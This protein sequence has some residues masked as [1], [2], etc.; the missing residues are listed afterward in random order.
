MLNLCLRISLCIC[1][2][3]GGMSAQLRAGHN[4]GL[5]IAYECLG[6]NSY[7]ITVNL[8]RDCGDPEPPASSIS[9]YIYSSCTNLGFETFDL[10]FTEEV[11]QLCPASLPN[12]TC[13]G[14]LEPGVE[15]NIYKKTV[16]L[17][18]CADWRMVVAEQNRS[19]VVNLVS[20][21]TSRIHVEAF[22]NNV[23][24]VCNSSPELGV[25]NL[26]YICVS[27]PL[28]YNLGFSEPDG[29]SLVYAFVPAL[30]SL[31]A[32]APEEMEYVGVYSGEEPI[33]GASINSGNGQI[34]VTPNLTG[35]FNAAVK[36]SE[37][38]D[39]VLIGEV[40]QDFLFLINPCPVPTPAP[41][42]GS[43]SHVS[44]GGY[45]LDNATIGI[46]EEDD[47][48][49]EIAFT[50]NDSSYDISI[51][52]TIETII[53][54]ATLTTTGSNPATAQFCGSMP[55][56]LSAG[57]FLII[58]TDD[59]CPV[60]GQTFY[61][62]DFVPRSPVAAGPDTLLCAGQP[63][64]LFAQNGGEHTWTYLNGM[65][66]PPGAAF[67][68][69]P[70]DNPQVVTDTTTTLLV[71]GAF[72]N[73][74]CANTA[75]VT[76]TVPLTWELDA[77][78]ES[79]LG[80]D[81]GIDIIISDG[82]GSYET[83][84]NDIGIGS[85]NRSGLSA[86]VYGFTVTD[87]VYGCARAG[88]VELTQSLF[89]TAFAGND[90]NVCGL[91]YTLQ[92]VPDIVPGSWLAPPAGATISDL[93]DPNALATVAS[94]GAY[95]FIW[96]ENAGNGCTDT[97]EVTITFFALPQISIAAP[98]SVCGFESAVAANE[99][100]ASVNWS[101]LNGLVFTDA[102]AGNTTITAPIAG[103]FTA[104]ATGSNGPC[105]TSDTALV[106]FIEAPLAIAGADVSVC[107]NVA[108]LIA[109]PSVGTGTWTLPTGA[110]ADPDLNSATVEITS[111]NF[112]VFEAVWWEENENFCSDSDTVEVRFTELPTVVLGNDTTIC[113]SAI[114]LDTST[115]VGN[116]NWLLPA[117]YSASNPQGIP[118]EI[119]G[120]YGAFTVALN[121]DN[122]FGCTATD[123]QTI[124]F[125]EQPTA[126]LPEAEAHC[127][128]STV[129]DAGANAE[130][131]TWSAAD[132]E[133][134]VTELG[135]SIAEIT[136]SAQGQFVVS[137]SAVNGGVCSASAT[138]ELSFFTS[139]QL[140]SYADE[141]V[142]G[143][144]TLIWAESQHGTVSWDVPTGLNSSSTGLDSLL[145]NA[146]AYATYTIPLAAVNGACT[147]LDTL[148]I[149]FSSSALILDPAWNC[150]GTDATY[151]LSFSTAMGSES[152]HAVTGLQGSF[153]NNFFESAPIPSSTE[154]QA[155]LTDGSICPGDT[156]SG[157][158]FCP[159]LTNAGT[160]DTDTLRVCGSEYAPATPPTNAVLDGND[161]LLYALH[162]GAGD[163]LD[164]LIAWS[165]SGQFEF[166]PPI[167]HNTIYYISAVVGNS[168]PD[169]VDLNDPFLSV[170]MGTPV[171]FLVQPAAQL[172][173]GDLIICPD[174]VAQFEV[175][176][177][178]LLPQQLAYTI[179]GTAFTANVDSNP[180][181]ITATDSGVY[182]L[183][184]TS[185]A[186]CSGDA[187]GTS[188]LNHY[189]LPEAILEGP[190]FYCAGDTAQLLIT[191]QGTPNF[192]FGISVNDSALATVQ[193]VI[194]MY[195][196]NLPEGG[197]YSV[198]S[199]SDANC[200]TPS[201]WSLYIDDR[202]GAIAD[203]GDLQIM[204]SGDT[205]MLGAAAIAGQQYNWSG[206]QG[207]LNPQAAMPMFTASNSQV[208]SQAIT[209]YLE[210]MRN[211]CYA[212]DS[213]TVQ[214]FNYP[215]VLIEGNVAYC[216]GDSILLLGYGNGAP[217]WS[218][219]SAFS[220]P[221]SNITWLTSLH[222]AHISLTLVNEAGCITTST[223]STDVWPLPASI[224]GSDVTE[225]C[226]PLDV[227]LEVFNPDPN[228]S[229]RWHTGEG[230]AEAGPVFNYI[231]ASAG[232]YTPWLMVTSAAGCTSSDSLPYP[233][234]VSSTRAN[235]SYY[236]E[237]PTTASPLV[238]FLN[239]SPDNVSSS[240]E[241]ANLGFSDIRNPNFNFPDT[242]AGIYEVCLTVT[243][244]EGCIASS[245]ETIKVTNELLLYIPNAFTP[246]G[247]GLN[248]LFGP[249]ISE[250]ELEDYHFRI[251][252]R[253]GRI[254]WE[255][256]AQGEKW[257]GSHSGNQHY[258]HNSLFIWQLDFTTS[259]DHKSHSFNGTVIMLR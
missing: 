90:A 40:T 97:S 20:P 127:G 44:G 121:S 254:I 246:D 186:W 171:I 39:G 163:A 149:T 204:C 106:H 50:S 194:G 124:T 80:N 187:T 210:V 129:L 4:S 16:T 21:E 37:Y 6:G 107:G 208:Q 168:T 191:L 27:N 189:A 141:E 19:P 205:V 132:P 161:T 18:P 5:N 100:S 15:L 10:T 213:T 251:V 35:V 85:L 115:P 77:A 170:A 206:H 60:M 84:W 217:S 219:A 248:D 110:T 255:S 28:F 245:C 123:T 220:H 102:T 259:K 31:I 12:S 82:S 75:T 136:A 181:F 158:L 41:V 1:L 58:A 63:L 73:S 112:G 233:I 231:Y 104:V 185:T 227:Q 169:G 56:G 101:S 48:C 236:P 242:R 234:E 212:I 159:V 55:P 8:F 209:L 2:L 228:F 244:P 175:Q 239:L 72:A 150:T 250:L 65:E 117:G 53:P 30:T 108:S 138:A 36:V 216:S 157:S 96:V 135:P 89:P 178:G 134:S 83:D 116:L 188:Q 66:P 61:A 144:E 26:P 57:S 34:S 222:G 237:K 229:Y 143:L 130:T 192:S 215:E 119:E 24:G 223:Q 148:S 38:R 145:L 87:L 184:T 200:I 179:D 3:L 122:G 54:G 42:A 207:L 235:F 232:N 151:V 258:E 71:T 133:L 238:Q 203:A 68:C 94:E 52:S 81:G 155:L 88:S 25:L 211:A 230:S 214:V 91:E 221:D 202:P 240:W 190:E 11:S 14:G 226:A 95:T 167:Q 182:Q 180:Y 49:F 162:S 64:T 125:V 241:F 153:A 62:I 59:A 23:D 69:N 173:T 114:E 118:T 43:L 224:F 13:A 113:G 70:C 252:D 152:T 22:L 249:V 165:A 201:S 46:C 137:F 197:N 147:E 103:T 9:V 196:Y 45:P 131:W 67:S 78:N 126:S 166:G 33:T 164:D 183:T 256:R 109:T 139:P 199:L 172:I 177:A 243:N 7:E 156:I 176:L 99:V 146:A 128:F 142:C 92:A 218:P 253:G 154:V 79:C 76:L 93:D 51:S 193:N 247:D 86:G 32:T 29:D 174:S 225:G 120:P 160:M 105:T 17:N 198:Y 195:S 74:S 257:N 111:P 47:F 98:D 140:A